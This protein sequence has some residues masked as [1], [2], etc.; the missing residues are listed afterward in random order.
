[1]KS[2][3]GFS[4]DNAKQLIGDTLRLYVGAHRRF[5]FADIAA[6]T[7]I[8]EGTLRSYVA[9]DGPE[10]PFHVL[11]QVFSVL[12]IEARGRVLAPLGV[13]V[14]EADADDHTTLRRT[15]AQASRLV[16]DG[17]EAL[18]D[19]ALDHR[20]RARLAD[21]AQNLLPAIQAMADGQMH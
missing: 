9:S 5:S 14:R 2:A 8:K 13:T 1:M 10:M 21:A 15:L 4:S 12:P 16:A 6:A 20:E 18:E 19:G 17:T 3:A 7:G 11:V